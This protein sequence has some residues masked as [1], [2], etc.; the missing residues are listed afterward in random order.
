MVWVKVLLQRIWELGIDWDQPVPDNLSS[1]WNQWRNELP[2]IQEY[3][4]ETLCEGKEILD[5]Q[6]HGFADVSTTA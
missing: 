2:C 6:L 1:F 4:Q 3:N 5:V